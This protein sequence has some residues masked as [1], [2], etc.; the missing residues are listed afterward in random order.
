MN[1]R[2]IGLWILLLPCTLAWAEEYPQP[3]SY[4]S[5]LQE[6]AADA[7]KAGV[8]PQTREN[9]LPQLRWRSEVIALDRKQP[10]FTS[11]FSRYFSRAVSPTR[12]ERG[13]ALLAEHAEL[14]RKL[15]K[16]YGLPGHYLLA[17]WGL[18]T[19]FGGYL[20]NTP[21]LDALATLGCDTRRSRYFRAELL[22]ALQL[23]DEQQLRPEDFRGSWAGALGLV[24]FMPSNYR[25][26]GQDGD[27]DGKVDLFGSIPDAL[28]SAAHFLHALG[29]Q[30]EQRW[31]REVRL[32]GGFDYTLADARTQ[33]PLRAW[34]KL[35]LRHANGGPLPVADFAA[36]LIVPSGHKG[37]AFVVYDNFK[38]I[39]R[40]NNS[41]FYALAVGHLAD[42]ILGAP[43]L[44]QNP[45]E[46]NRA[47]RLVL[48]Q[49]AQE[50]LNALGFEAGEPDG[51]VG[52]G[53]RA[54]I[55]RF[56]VQQQLVPDGYLDAQLLRALGIPLDE[57]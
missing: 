5:C 48:V 30:A 8:S 7:Q 52:S 53:T 27:G 3:E 43:G 49:A 11:S 15:Q 56:Q 24:Q 38:V 46:E 39:K 28:T 16:Q 18:E 23:V 19:N 4:A 29:W 35:G 26:Y 10:E 1:L 51:I 57:D 33:R 13:Q 9:I 44:V 37:P 42:R 50:K 47:L 17:F 6:L 45:P 21:S 22:A 20:G 40:W 54:A 34:Q 32:P 31:G 2:R 55:R 12:I 25:R 14:L 36:A 41:D